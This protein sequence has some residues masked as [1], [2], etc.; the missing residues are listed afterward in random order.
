M[1]SIEVDDRELEQA[2]KGVREFLQSL[3]GG[4]LEVGLLGNPGVHGS[5]EELWRIAWINELGSIQKNIPPRPFITQAQQQITSEFPDDFAREM[6]Q[7]HSVEEI[8]YHLGEK[9]AREWREIIDS[10]TTPPNAP[11]TIRKKG[12]DDPLV[13]TGAMRDAVTYVVRMR[14]ETQHVSRLFPDPSII[15]PEPSR[16]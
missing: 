6:A 2:L 7:G 13:E 12:F 14:H 11:A 1:I 10:W 16:D 8:L 5:R 15:R 4:E 9:Y 3:G